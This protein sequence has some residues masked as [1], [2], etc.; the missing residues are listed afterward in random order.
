MLKVAYLYFHTK[1]KSDYTLVLFI[2]TLQ[3]N[4]EDEYL[5]KEEKGATKTFYRLSAT[6]VDKAYVNTIM[7]FYKI[8][9]TLTKHRK[10]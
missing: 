10:H 9:M 5:Q 1:L 7:V 4:T 3:R 2:I 8:F 6:A